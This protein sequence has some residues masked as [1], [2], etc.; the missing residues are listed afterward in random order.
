MS[1]IEFNKD[2]L[3]NLNFS[4]K[5]ELLRVNQRGA[6]ASTTIV[7]CNTRKYHGLLVTPQPQLDNNIHVLLSSLDE[8]IQYENQN[9]NLGLH[10]Y[11]GDVYF[12]KGHKYLQNLAIDPVPN[13]VYRIGDC[14]ISKQIMFDSQ[15]D[16]VFIKYMV[17]ESSSILRLQL[18][19]FLAFRNVHGLCK[20]NEYL[21]TTFESIGQGVKMQ[22]YRGYT[23]IY[24]QL[25]K[26]NTYAH[27]PEWNYNIEYQE[28]KER[29]YDYIEDLYTPG[30]FELTL[31]TLESVVFTAGLGEINENN[32][33]DLYET[34]TRKGTPRNNYE[35]CLL[36]SAH[37][38]II[39]TGNRTEVMAGYP[40]FGRWGRDTFIA[41]PG[42][43][44]VTG[45][46]DECKAVID[47]MISE[48][49]GPLFP[50]IG[51]G[52]DTAF[53]SIDAPLWFFWAL[54]Q[55]AEYT[56]TKD[57][58]WKEYGEKM[59]MV[60][61]GVRKGT[62]YNIH[63]TPEGLVW[64][65]QAGKALTWMDAVVNGH[66]VTPRIGMPVEINALWYNAMMFS[67]EMAKLAK[68]QAFIEEWEPIAADFP[69]A[70]KN[71]F[72]CKEF[73][74][75]A[76]Y[77]YNDY[78]DFS[79]RPNMIFAASLP[80]SPLSEKIRQLVVEKVRKELLTPRGLRT[81][82]PTHPDYK[83]HYYGNQE[84]RDSAYHQGTV[85]PWLI[86]HFAEAYL[87]IYKKSGVAFIKNLYEGFETAMTEHGV[88]SISEVYDGNPPY[89]PGGS[90]SQAWSVAEV[91]RMKWLADKYEN[92]EL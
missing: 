47:T 19:P 58:I 32:L 85:W 28:E 20:A 78:K 9:F 59:K 23:P 44:L 27:I 13:Q 83:E 21:N 52:D 30:I 84:E 43:T 39:K 3:V 73:G 72:W 86:G 91:L 63:I 40:W 17:L 62:H 15:A 29:G 61:Y 41:L 87:K 26:Q 79:I 92:D 33:N 90:P 45:Q 34:N 55:Y 60:L 7:G 64:G 1:Y 10:K 25:S 89:L 56:N 50:N 57:K 14:L 36:N 81:L 65:G 31:S 71:T 76:D 5:R 6:Y 2:E 35:N 67:I 16:R 66:G 69:N 75:L 37:Q 42:L 12:P 24:M 49:N 80:Y 77:V 4:L 68:D 51:S 82:S 53:N 38:F 70:F 54:Q 74:W 48:L 18:K 88:C 22:P 11:A 46:H 8:T